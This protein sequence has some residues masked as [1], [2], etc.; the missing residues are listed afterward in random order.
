MFQ[1]LGEN[2]LGSCIL[3]NFMQTVREMISLTKKNL[4]FP[5]YH[6]LRCFICTS[7]RYFSTLIKMLIFCAHALYKVSSSWL[8]WFSSCNTNK[9]SNGQERDITL[10]MFYR[11]KSHLNMDPKQYWRWCWR[12]RSDPIMFMYITIYACAG[13]GK[14]IGQTY[15]SA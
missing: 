6:L 13:P 12:R 14:R 15:P 1:A 4:S 5:S 3:F 8:K 9:K 11:I 10:P 2:S 7:Y